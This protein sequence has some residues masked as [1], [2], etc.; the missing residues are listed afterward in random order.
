M[1]SDLGLSPR[2]YTCSVMFGK[3]LDY[4]ASQFPCV[5]IVFRMADV[6]KVDNMKCL[7]GFGAIGTVALC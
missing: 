3:L 2:N 7:G 5:K 1:E 4:F 6:K